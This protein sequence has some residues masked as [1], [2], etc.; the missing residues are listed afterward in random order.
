MNGVDPLESGPPR[1]SV[2]WPRGVT[3]E[4]PKNG[5]PWYEV[6][7]LTSRTTE[8]NTY[9]VTYVYDRARQ[10]GFVY[11][12]GETDPR[13]RENTSLLLR[14]NEGNWFYAWGEWDAAVKPLL[15]NAQ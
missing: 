13:Y 10:Q 9:R 11:L 1:L 7:F 3:T 8:M 5:L 14:H 6:E 2:D 12:P 4:P 15:P